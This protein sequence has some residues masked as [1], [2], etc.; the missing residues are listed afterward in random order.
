MVHPILPP[1]EINLIR[2]MFNKYSKNLSS[3]LRDM[4]TNLDIYII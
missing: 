4:N 3:D 2:A 1:L